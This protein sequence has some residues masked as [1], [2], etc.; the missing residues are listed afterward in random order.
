MAWC[1]GGGG[2]HTGRTPNLKKNCLDQDSNPGPP[3]VRSVKL[4]HLF[5]QVYLLTNLN[6]AIMC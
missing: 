1:G 5:I 6:S 3:L 2:V 4:F